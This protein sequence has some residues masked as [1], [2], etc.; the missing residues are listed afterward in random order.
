MIPPSPSVTVC[1]VIPTFN[2]RDKLRECLRAVQAQ[3]RPVDGCIV[4]DNDSTDGTSQMVRE[5]FPHVQLVV[6]P[7]NTGSAGGFATGLEAAYQQGFTWLWALDNDV[8]ATPTA[9]AALL[10]TPEKLTPGEL[11]SALTSSVLWTDGRPHP[12][13]LPWLDQ[14][15]HLRLL[16]ALRAGS[17]PIRWASWASLLLHR[18]VVRDLGLPRT[19][20]FLWCDDLEYTTRITR[21]RLALL[22]A[23]SIVYHHT[24]TPY[25]GYEETSGRY[26]FHVRNMIHTLRGGT[27][28]RSEAVRASWWLVR[29]CVRYVQRSPLRRRALAIVARGVRDGFRRLVVPR[30]PSYERLS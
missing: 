30:D 20:F 23:D 29:D 16:R 7:I 28:Y 12:M 15:D 21:T 8:T 24:S 11:P 26:Y 10:S 18:D 6:N 13:N 22:V 3:T 5:E 1:A 27:L 2:R 4:I 25:L 17:V 9:I 19:E 14:S